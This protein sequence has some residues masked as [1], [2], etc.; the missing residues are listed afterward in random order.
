MSSCGKTATNPDGF[1]RILTIERRKSVQQNRRS[2]YSCYPKGAK[3]LRKIRSAARALLARDG[4]L[5]FGLETVAT[6]RE[7]REPKPPLET[8]AKE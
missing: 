7:P 8:F 1:V 3:A 5:Y 2:D 6:A 4:R